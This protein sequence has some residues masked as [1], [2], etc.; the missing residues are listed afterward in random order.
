MLFTDGMEFAFCGMVGYMIIL[1][2][3]YFQR[4]GHFK[5]FWVSLFD[6]DSRGTRKVKR[7][8]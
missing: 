2:D 7:R 3:R 1:H 4:Q 6:F 8:N 5:V